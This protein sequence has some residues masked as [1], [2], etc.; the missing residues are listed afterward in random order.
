MKFVIQLFTCNSISTWNPDCLLKYF[1]SSHS[2]WKKNEIKNLFFWYRFREFRYKC[3]KMNIKCTKKFKHFCFYCS[4]KFKN[5]LY[6]KKKVFS[7][8]L[9]STLMTGAVTQNSCHQIR[10][11]FIFDFLSNLSVQKN[12]TIFAQ[13]PKNYMMVCILLLNGNE[14]CP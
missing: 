13:T 11:Q 8:I 1:N 6:Q 9:F 14:K 3:L 12:L 2:F 10:L 4:I 7:I 5:C